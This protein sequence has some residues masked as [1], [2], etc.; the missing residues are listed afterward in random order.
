MLRGVFPAWKLHVEMVKSI[1]KLRN[2]N[3]CEENNGAFHNNWGAY[4]A[5]HHNNLGVD[6]LNFERARN[7]LQ[8]NEITIV[9]LVI[10]VFG[11]FF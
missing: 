8:F 10:F 4:R 3:I 7:S 11:V 9:V 2:P 6:L 5:R 1:K